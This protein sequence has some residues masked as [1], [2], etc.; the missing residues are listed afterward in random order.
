MRRYA[1]LC[2]SCFA[3]LY[4]T[5]VLV[6]GNAEQAAELVERTCVRGVRACDGM[7]DVRMVK[8]ELTGIL[9]R[10][11]NDMRFSYQPGQKG[12]TEM[13]ARLDSYER[14]VVIFRH[15][16]GL[17]ASEFSRA[18]GMPPEYMSSLLVQLRQKIFA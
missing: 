3:D 7:K 4:R 18:L 16:S 12:Y 11:C 17:K 9:F 8:T 1:E 10:I 14:A 6:A 13:L 2:E 15:C 5:A